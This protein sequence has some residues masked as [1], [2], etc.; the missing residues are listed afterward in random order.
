MAPHPAV[1]TAIRREA[2]RDTTAAARQ[3]LFAPVP[4]VFVAAG[5]APDG[6]VFTE[7]T[8]IAPRPVERA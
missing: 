6:D 1:G 8:A 5:K 4:P 7:T 2:T 3:V